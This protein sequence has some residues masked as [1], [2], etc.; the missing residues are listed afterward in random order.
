ML[1]RAV[2]LLRQVRGL[3][4]FRLTIERCF[5]H[6]EPTIHGLPCFGFGVC[7]SQ[8]MG[9][10]VQLPPRAIVAWSPLLLGDAR[11][12]ILYGGLTTDDRPR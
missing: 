12:G 8:N 6:V 3:F 10:L 5:E 4:P 7:Q 11:D 2:V 9:F 1:P